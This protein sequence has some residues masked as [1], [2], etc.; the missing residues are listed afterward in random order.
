MLMLTLNLIGSR[1]RDVGR[2]TRGGEAR[3]EAVFRDSCNSR[4]GV[5]GGLGGNW[6]EDLI[7]AGD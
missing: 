6:G 5:S 1:W 2:C 7:D 4:V 3:G